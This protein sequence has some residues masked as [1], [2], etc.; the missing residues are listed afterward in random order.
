MRSIGVAERALDLMLTRITDPRKKTFGKQLYEHGACF[1]SIRCEVCMFSFSHSR[2]SFL[3]PAS[4]G[5]IVAEVA[6]SRL[7]IDQ[8]RLLVLSAANQIDR[9][10]AKGAMKDI[11]MSKI[12]VPT[13][14]L[15]VVDRAMQ[16]HGAE[17]ICQDT[18]LA[19]AWAQLRTLRYADGPD[20]VHMAQLGKTEVRCEPDL[21]LFERCGEG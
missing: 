13:A 20:E 18:M 19:N 9:L 21:P 2:P 11:G 4:A 10:Q 17:G 15:D 3:A 16:A 8:A 7:Q 5:T 12:V 14:A 6:K 1:S